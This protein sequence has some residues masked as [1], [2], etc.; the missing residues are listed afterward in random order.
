MT[1]TTPAF[2]DRLKKSFDFA[3][4]AIKQQITLATVI[5]TFT[6]TFLK[7]IATDAGEPARIAMTVAW[8]LLVVS[9][10]FGLLAL[11]VMTGTL[12]TASLDPSI[13]RRET[14]ILALLQ[15]G[16]FAI[17]LIAILVFAVLSG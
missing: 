17:A 9:A 10:V 13:N 11:L 12:A 5:L 1:P 6:I 7:D 16:A 14:R 3:Q 8:V 15:L 4:D 2:D